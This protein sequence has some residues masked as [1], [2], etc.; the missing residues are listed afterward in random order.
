MAYQDN[1]DDM[2]RLIGQQLDNFRVIER[3]GAGG[4]ATVF[5]AYQPSL[6]RYVAIK[7]LPTKQAQ[8]PIFFK[9]FVQ[10][11]RSIAR[12]AHPNIVHIYNFGEE[13]DI[14][15]IAMEYV[16]GGT[17]KQRLGKPLPVRQAADFVIQAAQGLAC[18]HSNGI[19]HRDIKPANMLLRKNGHLLLTDF[20]LAKILED[21]TNITRTGARLGT[22]HYMSPEQGTGRPVDARTDIYSLGIVLFQCLAGEPPFSADNPLSMSVKH[23][24]DPLP[25]QKLTANNAVPD[26]IVQIILKMTAKQPNERYQSAHELIDALS[27]AVTATEAMSRRNVLGHLAAPVA[28]PPSATP[29]ALEPQNNNASRSCF[30]CGEPNK[31]SRLFCTVCGYDLSNKRASADRYMAANGLPLLA[32]LSPQ[33]GPLAGRA[34]RFHQDTTTIGRATGNDL[35]VTG[36]TVSRYHAHLNFVE[37]HWYVEDLQ[38]ANGTKVNGKRIQERTFLKDGDLINFGDERVVFNIVTDNQPGMGNAAHG[39]RPQSGPLQGRSA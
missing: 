21:T 35:V 32:R 4:M 29:P 2:E 19:I 39:S 38:S 33:S 26:P 23:L 37:G 34:L 28:P 11:A 25:V 13:G 17:L 16:E 1:K 5:R 20:G 6:D 22:P 8:D 30:R 31:D 9:R 36:R 7:V 27:N 12:L 3:I 14:K 18:A 10:E 24:Q 15:Y